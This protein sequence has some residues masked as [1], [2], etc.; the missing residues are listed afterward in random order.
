MPQFVTLNSPDL[1]KRGY[2]VLRELRTELSLPDFHA[3]YD[4]AHSRDGFQLVAA[5]EDEKI[6]G[7]MGYRILFDFVHGK[8]LYIDDLVTTESM[9]GRG[10]GA[11]LLK[12][13]ER[14]AKDHGC[15]ALRL[16]TGT[17]NER[18]K[19][20]YQREGWSLRSVAYKKKVEG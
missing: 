11:K 13:A 15:V 19:T 12:E 7:I 16:C 9:R 14:I 18:A 6:A 8:H 17:A 1:L 10:I 5:V 20:F 3:I 4:Q 2:A